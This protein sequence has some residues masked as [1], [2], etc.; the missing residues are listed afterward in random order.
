[1]GKID[2][3]DK[4]DVPDFK[5][6]KD[7]F[8]SL[9]TDDMPEQQQR[10]IGKKLALEYHENLHNDLNNF[11]KSIGVKTEKYVSPDNSS[12]IKEVN[13]KYDKLISESKQ[14]TQNN[15][16]SQI[17]NTQNENDNATS[18][19]AASQTDQS[20]T[21]NSKK[22]EREKG[23]IE[24]AQSVTATDPYDR[25]L[26]HFSGGGKID[27]SV[28]ESLFGNN[29]KSTEGQRKSMIGLIKKGGQ[30]IDQLAHSLWESDPNENHTTQDYKNAIEDALNSHTSAASMAKELVS[31]ND[32]DEAMKKFLA[33]RYG[34]NLGSKEDVLDAVNI[35]EGMS[36]EEINHLLE[37]DADETKQ[38]E[39]GNYIDS[40]NTKSNN[41]P[42]SVV[43]DGKNTSQSDDGSGITHAATAQT[44]ENLNLPEYEKT[45]KKDEDLNAEAD[46]K[47]KDGYDAEK[48]IDK[49]EKGHQPTDVENTI[50]KKYKAV[51][52]AKVEKDPSDKNISDLY[53]LVKASD[54]IGSEQGRALRSRQGFDLVDDS[55]G[56]FFIR[57]MDALNVDELT[58]DQKA[59]IQKEFENIQKANEE[60]KQR[61]SDLESKQSE[62]KAAESVKKIKPEKNTKKSH[63][64]FVEDR[65]KI[66]SD[67][68]DKL[69]KARNST[70]VSILPYANEL[71]AIAPEVAKLAKS[72]VEEGIVKLEDVVKN[73]HGQ[74][75]EFIPDIQ[76][77]DVHDILA[78]EY[79]EKKKT[80]N[81]ITA[82][83]RD[84]RD[85]AK[86]VNKLNSVL[87]G[88]EPAAPKQKIERNQQ[89]KDL[90][91]KIKSIQKQDSENNK[92]YTEDVLSDAKKLRSAKDNIESQ[93]KKLEKD[94]S[95]GNLEKEEAK[96][97]IL[98]NKE[99]QKKYP[100]LY[101]QALDAKDRLIKL[102][103]EREIRVLREQYANRSRFQ[104]IKDVATN[105]LNT[106]RTIMASVDYSA[107]LRQGIIAS[108]GH[109]VTASKAFVEMFKQSLSQKRFDRWHYDLQE[110]PE[111]KIMEKSGLYVADPHNPILTAKEEQFMN[112]LAEKIPVIGKL[113]KGSERAYTAYLNKLRVD[114]FNKSIDAFQEN[115]QTFENSPELYKGM[116]SFINNAT[117]RG[118]LGK[119]EGSAQTLNT[120]FF[121]PRLIAARLNMLNPVYYAK[122]PKEI[123]IKALLS[124][125]KFIGVGLSILSLAKLNG[126]QVEKDP[127]STD[128]GKIKFK[129]SR[130]DIWGGF[131]QYVRFMGQMLSG[132]KKSTKTGQIQK[133]G[134]KYGSQ[135]RFDALIQFAR[136]KLAPVPAETAS[137]LAGKSSVGQPLS[138][139][140]EAQNLLE[141]LLFQDIQD[142]WKT[143]G[144]KSI[145]TIGLPS[146]FGVG[147]QTQ[148]PIKK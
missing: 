120:L 122:L 49:I 145:A 91:D 9:V 11:K 56:G 80:K 64:D 45:T 22:T 21:D 90:R 40:L 12:K 123:R 41:A 47:I 53:R 44:R 46:A 133:M 146:M 126:L 39:L 16:N 92:F 6:L 77:K 23:I 137:L 24:R 98:E 141:P 52:E 140:T 50:L 19:R 28:V 59:S 7:K 136:G 67:I 57:E 138:L 54:A 139:S 34:E 116:A 1:M 37:L 142:A 27:N 93:I 113:I 76:E 2:C 25:V 110:S 94:L 135:T 102:K 63:T 147:V 72:L 115:G 134:Q 112:N 103:Q 87:S 108:V 128:F 109:P 71:I 96:K 88:K 75:K 143:Q 106:P 105:I 124:M 13:D 114:L 85:E 17:Q 65:K 79:N 127:R 130:W 30:T 111:F 18:G 10:E 5:G 104:K 58:A 33:D 101:K 148:T 84:L 55:L 48:L 60:L 42:P 29:N 78:G 144:A 20:G 129:D 69:K 107:P 118:N 97:P 15:N 35:V 117:G 36:A 81:E 43:N 31:R 82:K 125:A 83:L 131:Q 62:N 95:E 14:A 132:E 100:E 4:I 38:D 51:L 119:L 66:V 8:N 70:N 99:L 32:P 74:L 89:I 3:F 68:R 73:I 26:Q 121:S 61:V 86:L